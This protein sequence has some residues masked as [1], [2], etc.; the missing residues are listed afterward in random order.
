MLRT[1]ERGG[2]DLGRDLLR[3]VAL[4]DQLRDAV[5][6][7][8][9]DFLGREGRPQHDVAHQAQHR[10][11]RVRQR[12]HVDRRGIH[13]AVGPERATEA[14]ELVGDLQRI[15]RRGAFV[16]HGGGEVR[17][18][19]LVDRIRVAAGPEDELRRHDRQRAAL[20]ENQCQA[21]RERR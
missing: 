19:R 15:P 9:L 5:R 12:T 18:P 14:G 1:V 10:R 13:R 21:V 17:Q 6:P 11:E 8:A 20:V 3:V 4:L 2:R 7:L 16:Q